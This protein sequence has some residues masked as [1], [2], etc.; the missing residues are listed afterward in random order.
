MAKLSLDLQRREEERRRLEAMDPSVA[1]PPVR[2]VD[3][4]DSNEANSSDLYYEPDGTGS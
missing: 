1:M 2:Y 4:E 3:N